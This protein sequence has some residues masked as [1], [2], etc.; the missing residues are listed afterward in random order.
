[1][2]FNKKHSLQN[3][4]TTSAPCFKK[5]RYSI[6]LAVTA[7]LY[8]QALWAQEAKDISKDNQ[9]IE[10]IE[11][12]SSPFSSQNPTRIPLSAKEL[13]QSVTSISRELMDLSGITD[14]NDIMLNV[15]GVNVT[16]S[17]CAIAICLAR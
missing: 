1:M 2:S 9:D 7:A 6:A 4:S 17:R 8:G 13:P 5:N 11:V 3:T 15:P 14:M 10:I 12:K 16:K